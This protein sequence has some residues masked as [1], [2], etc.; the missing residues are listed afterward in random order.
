MVGLAQSHI[1]MSRVE[2]DLHRRVE[3]L[4][5]RPHPLRYARLIL[6]FGLG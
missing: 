2:E 1:R 4:G 5:E 6:G 3:P